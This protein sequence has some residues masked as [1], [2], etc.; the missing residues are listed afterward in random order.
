[1]L[2]TQEEL[3]KY[4]KL[5]NKSWESNVFHEPGEKRQ[6]HQVAS[7][8]GEICLIEEMNRRPTLRARLSFGYLF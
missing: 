4:L 2:Y 6:F 7:P 3:T 1:M 5:L 8:D